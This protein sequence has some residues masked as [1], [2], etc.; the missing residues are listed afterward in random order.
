MDHLAELENRSIYIIRE[1]YHQFRRPAALWSV[2]KDSTTL[3]W[4]CTK[5]FFGRVPM[6]VIH[7]D[8]GYKFAEMYEFRDLL[9]RRW[10][11]I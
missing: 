4:L 3:L 5:S 11:L 9:A 6:P 7:I 1:A 2:G 8:T 10:G